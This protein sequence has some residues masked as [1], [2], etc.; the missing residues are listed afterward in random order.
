M[1]PSMATRKKVCKPWDKK[2]CSEFED[3]PATS[4]NESKWYRPWDMAIHRLFPDC[5]GFQV[6]PQ[7]MKSQYCGKPEWMIFYWIKTSSLPVCIIEIKPYVHLK[8]LQAWVDAYQQVEAH[9]KV[10]LMDKHSIPRMYGVLIIG[11]WFL[12][13]MIDT[14]ST[15]VISPLH[16]AALIAHVTPDLYW[17]NQVLKNSGHHHLTEMVDNIHTLVEAFPPCIPPEISLT[18]EEEEESDTSSLLF[19]PEDEDM[20]EELANGGV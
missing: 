11:E 15:V 1:S 16:P 2:L 4:T 14:K 18:S 3:V 9:L 10:L 8:Q 13:M 7:H 19:C 5:K 6:A 12:I 20:G 17:Q